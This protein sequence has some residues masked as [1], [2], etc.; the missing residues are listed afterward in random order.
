MKLMIFCY[1]PRGYVGD[2]ILGSP[3]GNSLSDSAAPGSQTSTIPYQPRLS[4]KWAWIWNQFLFGGGLHYH[5][6]VENEKHF[7]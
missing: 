3:S 4:I 6:M 5:T 2:V 7:R 1:S